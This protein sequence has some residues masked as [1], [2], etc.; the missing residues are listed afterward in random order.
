MGSLAYA[1]P[2]PI[3]DAQL[4]DAVAIAD[5]HIRSW[6]AAYR[7]LL[8]AE[9]LD[10]L[11]D[12]LEERVKWWRRVLRREPEDVI[13]ATED[14]RVVG[15]ARVAKCRDE[16]HGLLHRFGEVQAIYLVESAWDK[17]HGRELMAAAERR[18]A[19]RRLGP[20]CVWVLA[21]N[22]RARRFYEA[23]GWA[24]DGVQKEETMP[25]ATLHEVRYV[26]EVP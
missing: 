14:D 13:V 6:Q 18:L 16:D 11:G 20:L 23:A 5:A 9:F 26:K 22:E 17:G 21:R 12:H 2:V 24:T 15:F 8:P 10:G 1:Q 25:W 4:D 3:R 7:D 19:Q